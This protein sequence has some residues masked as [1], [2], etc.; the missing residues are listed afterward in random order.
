MEI[1]LLRAPTHEDWKRCYALALNT[2]WKFSD[3]VPS[4]EWKNRIVKAQHSPIRTLM[5]TVELK[6][7]PYYCAIHLVRHKYGVE[8]YVSSQRNDRQDMYDRRAAR[9]DSPVT[10]IA[11]MN[12]QAFINISKRRLCSQADETTRMIWEKVA[13]AVCGWET[14]LTELAKAIQPDCKNCGE[15]YP[16]GRKEI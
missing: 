10:V 6:D 11:D 12:M 9:Q 13:D 1:R 15:F 3:K 2:V 14:E 4:A 7:I 16:C 8:W 5:Y